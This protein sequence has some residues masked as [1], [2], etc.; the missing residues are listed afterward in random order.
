[1]ELPKKL[2]TPGVY[3]D[4]RNAFPNSEVGVKTSV[5][6]FLGYTEEAK[7]KGQS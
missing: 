1:M 5:P 6:D 3:I 7:F 4:E 2:K